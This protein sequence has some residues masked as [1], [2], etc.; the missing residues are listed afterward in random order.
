V[1][2]ELANKAYAHLFIVFINTSDP[3]TKADPFIYNIILKL[4]YT[5]IV[6]IGIMVNISVFKKSI[7]SYKQF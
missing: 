4:Y 1:S 2:I 5:F 6:F 3:V 7:I